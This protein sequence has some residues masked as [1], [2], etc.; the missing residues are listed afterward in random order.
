MG[1]KGSCSCFGSA[2]GAESSKVL[3]ESESLWPRF[4]RR[5]KQKSKNQSSKPAAFSNYAVQ[6]SPTC[7]ISEKSKAVVRIVSISQDGEFV[8]VIL[9]P[10]GKTISN[11][12]QPTKK[13]MQLGFDA[14]KSKVKLGFESRK[15]EVCTEEEDEV[16]MKKPNRR[17]WVRIANAFR[18]LKV[19]LLLLAHIRGYCYI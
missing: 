18:S 9:S 7:L 17:S 8:P 1:A 3:P 5:I 14:A 16:T 13:K 15:F 2:M 10:V 19:W 12:R 6:I 11:E 4:K